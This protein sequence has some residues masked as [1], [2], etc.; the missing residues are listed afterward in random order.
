MAH[1]KRQAT[2]KHG[3]RSHTAGGL[4]SIGRGGVLPSRR[5]HR[6]LAHRVCSRVARRPRFGPSYIIDMDLRGRPAR[7]DPSGLATLATITDIS[8]PARG[9]KLFSLQPAQ[10]LPYKAGQWLDVYMPTPGPEPPL[11]GGYSLTKG[12]RTAE[13]SG[14]IEFAVKESTHPPARW[15]HE[16]VR[17]G[18]ISRAAWVRCGFLPW[19]RDSLAPYHSLV[20][21]LD[22]ATVGA[23]LELAVGGQVH[24]SVEDIKTLDRPT[25][26]IFVAG[27][28]GLRW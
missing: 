22:Q 27:G 11:L 2:A 24:L 20:T 8:L 19:P 13:A 23:E 10:P 28:I 18:C 5:M 3:C 6:V 7:L 26:F 9:T 21:L 12:P 16:E 4:S 14:L 15:M 25:R 1:H 17:Q